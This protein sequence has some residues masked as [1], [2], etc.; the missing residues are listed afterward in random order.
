[1]VLSTSIDPN[2]EIP[3]DSQTGIGTNSEITIST[4]PQI[5]SGSDESVQAQIN[6]RTA[7]EDDGSCIYPIPEVI[8]PNVFTPNTDSDND[9]F[10]LKTI[11]TAELELIITN[12]WG[13]VMYESLSA[14]P[15]WDGLSPSGSP[16][17]EGVYFYR[18]RAY[19]VQ[20]SGDPVEGHG[21]FHL[22]R[23]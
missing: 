18:Y 8:V 22:V 21:F 16:A 17:A 3:D 1:M 2:S 23:D 9:I 6:T 20:G 11:N 19:G 10:F 12:R 13:N 4:Q 5:K 7:V 15:G 14:N